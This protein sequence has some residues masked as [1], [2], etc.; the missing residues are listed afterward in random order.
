M[1]T[2]EAAFLLVGAIE[3]VPRLHQKLAA[4]LS[5]LTIQDHPTIFLSQLSPAHTSPLS[6]FCLGTSQQKTWPA[7]EC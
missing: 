4:G 5:P 6:G 1:S 3:S 7:P 2:S